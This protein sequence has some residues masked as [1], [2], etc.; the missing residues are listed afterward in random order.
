[1]TDVTVHE[2]NVSAAEGELMSRCIDDNAAEHVD[3]VLS[4]L[5]SLLVGAVHR[6]M[7]VA[8]LL[9]VEL[10]QFVVGKVELTPLFQGAGMLK[11]A[12]HS[13]GNIRNWGRYT[14]RQTYRLTVGQP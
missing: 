7:E 5:P 10:D 14:H 3:T 6:Q 2:R 8:P 9:A 1:M 12:G 11:S 13:T 4:F